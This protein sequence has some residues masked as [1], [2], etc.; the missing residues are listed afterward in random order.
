MTTTWRW[1]NGFDAN[2][3]GSLEVTTADRSVPLTVTVEGRGTVEPGG[4][5]G[6]APATYQMVAEAPGYASLRVTREVL[7]GATT[8][9]EFD[10]APELSSATEGRVAPALVAIRWMQDGRQVCVNGVMARPGGLVLT[11]GSALRRNTGL[12]VVT[13]TGTYSDVSVAASDAGLDL[14]VLRVDATQQPTLPPA[15]GVSDE[16]HA[17]SLFRTGCGDAT[18]AHTR[19]DGWRSPPAGPVGLAPALPPGALGGPLF[20]RT[21]ALIGLVTGAERVAPIAL[22]QDLLARA[23]QDVVAEAQV[24]GGGLPWVW[25]GAGAAAVGVAAAVLGGGGGVAVAEARPPRRR[26]VSP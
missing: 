10:L 25:I 8:V 6:L 20:D 19:L 18:S 4:S 17:W 2:A 26:G 5:L 21:G 14:A 9:L 16:E 11:A 15:G 1:P 12:S 7:P 3:S 24:G 13:T 22:A 23:T